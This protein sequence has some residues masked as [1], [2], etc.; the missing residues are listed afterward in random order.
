MPRHARTRTAV[1]SRHC[2][3][4]ATPAAGEEPVLLGIV[5][6]SAH[7]AE[8]QARRELRHAD[9]RG[10]LEDLARLLHTLSRR[11]TTVYGR[12]FHP[13]DLDRYCAERGLDPDAPGSHGAYTDDPSADTEWVRY[14]GQP[15][16]VFLRA[17]LRG[18]ERG[19]V[20][21][22]LERL[23]LETAEAA[24]TGSFPE[25]LLRRA[26]GEGVES[27]RGL[28]AGAEP[29]PYR[30][31]CAVESDRG[32]VEVCVPLELR[33][34]E[35]M[36][37]ADPDLDLLCSLMCTAHALG[38]RGR[39]LLHGPTAARG[40]RFDGRGFVR[41]AAADLLLDFSAAVAAALAAP[42]GQGWDEALHDDLTEVSL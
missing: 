29:G 30:L 16:P 3:D 38:L 20:H 21:R 34:A 11:G 18:R 28:L 8:L 36:R 14:R 27:L 32:P 31:A 13:G 39:A 25:I 24:A 7:F 26:Y 1:S 19:R 23:L 42:A 2:A 22:L 10:Y 5:A 15:L 41:H 17:L 33:P 12:Q 40:W 37:L 35:R 6:D 4:T 9:Y